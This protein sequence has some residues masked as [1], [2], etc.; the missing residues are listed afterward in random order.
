[1]GVSVIQAPPDG[2]SSRHFV[3]ILCG[4]SMARFVMVRLE[5][6]VPAHRTRSVRAVRSHAEGRNER[7]E[8]SQHG[9]QGDGPEA[10]QP[11]R[12]F[13]LVLVRDRLRQPRL[14]QRSDGVQ[15]KAACHGT[16]GHGDQVEDRPCAAR[17]PSTRG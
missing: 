12:L 7:C 1:M 4:V 8:N 15:G 6:P 9:Q 11:G 3:G 5:Q 10:R 14:D 17:A 2:N 13:R 16:D